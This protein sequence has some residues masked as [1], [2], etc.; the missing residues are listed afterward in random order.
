MQGKDIPV[1]FASSLEVA[2][3]TS[4]GM[5]HI[6]FTRQALGQRTKPTAH[7]THQG[8]TSETA[9][10]E[11]LPSRVATIIFPYSRFK[12]LGLI[13]TKLNEEMIR[14]QQKIAESQQ[15]E[16]GTESPATT[17]GGDGDA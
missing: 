12:S 11:E 9:S 4:D 14:A 7:G 10:T 5:V 3:P 1:E 15:S 6:T 8:F 17:S 13:F 16:E 2:G